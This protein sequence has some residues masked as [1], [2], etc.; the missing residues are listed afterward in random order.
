MRGWND[1][2]AAYPAR[3]RRLHELIEEQAERTP[4]RVAVQ[5]EESSLT[6]RE[7]EAQANQLCHFLRRHGVGPGALVGIAMERSLEMVVGLLGILKAG[8]GLRAAG[9][10]LSEGPAGVHDGRLPGPGSADPG[11]AA[12][13]ASRPRC[14]GGGARRGLAGDRAGELGACRL[15]GHER[16]PGLRDLHVGLDGQAQG[17]DEHA[18]RDREP[19]P[20][21][22]GRVR[23]RPGRRLAAEDSVQFRRVRVG[24]LLAAVGRCPPRDGTTGGPQG[25]CLSRADDRGAGH[26]HG[27]LCPAD[28]PGLPGGAGSRGLRLPPAGLLQR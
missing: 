11:P 2:A 4:D 8:R 27:A 10:H 22:A 21:A 15:V 24:V 19:D 18:P 3:D 12:R 14:A 23:A 1:T 20:V 17:G 16:R 9:S 26:H 25:A 5:A 13:V 6:Y 28:A 7:L